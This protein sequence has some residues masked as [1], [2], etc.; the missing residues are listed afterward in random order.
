MCTMM[1]HLLSTSV[2]SFSFPIKM[3]KRA[4]G[5]NLSKAQVVLSSTIPTKYDLFCCVC[6]LWSSHSDFF[7]L[8]FLWAMKDASKGF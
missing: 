2:G 6:M 5:G 8:L 3:L 4:S 7:L 1:D